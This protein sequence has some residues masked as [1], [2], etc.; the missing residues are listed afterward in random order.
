VKIHYFQRYHSKENVHT[1]NAMLLL[2]RL[3]QYSPSKFFD[4]LG[5][6]L[7]DNA[8]IQLEF[9]IQDKVSGGTVPDATIGQ[10][11]FKIAI[12]TKLDGNFTLNQ[13]CGHIGTFKNEN[14]KVLMTLDPNPMHAKFTIQL[15]QM[16]AKHNNTANDH[17]IHRHMTFDEIVSQIADVIDD[18]DRDI[19]DVVND[20]REY[21]Y[22]SGLIPNDWKRM[23]VQL[24]STTLAVNKTLNLYYDNVAR[25][26]SGHKYLGLY[27]EKSVRAIGKILAIA[28]IVPIDG[29]LSIEGEYGAITEEMKARV[30][31]AI[32]DGKNKGY[33][34]HTSKHRYFFV[35]EFID[36]DF[37]KITKG[38]PMGTR[39]FDLCEVLDEDT[40]PNT[41]TIAEELRS[42]QWH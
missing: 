36:T 19:Q 28:V 5:N 15:N 32:D 31:K 2:S 25:G 41:V 3:Y 29:S 23:R 12:E 20:Y 11:S 7:P 42:K 10:A 21:C 26:F 13:L 38:A 17:V 22:S 34:L 33:T 30:W 18:R 27:S 4:F 1:S 37:K 16:L 39:M 8:D 24:A 35:E 14:Y 40:L 9:N 6:I